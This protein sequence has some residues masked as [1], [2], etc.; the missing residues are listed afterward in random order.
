MSVYDSST[1]SRNENDDDDDELDQ[2]MKDVLEILYDENGKLKPF[3]KINTIVE[4]D[5]CS[6]IQCVERCMTNS[7]KCINCVKKECVLPCNN[8]L[9]EIQG[10]CPK[11]DKRSFAKLS[12]AERAIMIPLI[13]MRERN[14]LKSMNL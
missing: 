9:F 13:K 1:S 8:I 12:L 3:Q 2:E 10:Y 5:Y 7:N 11:I 14:L 4:M 6:E